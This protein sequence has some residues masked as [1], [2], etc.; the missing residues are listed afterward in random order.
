MRVLHG[1]ARCPAPAGHLVSPRTTGRQMTMDKSIET[2]NPWIQILWD[3]DGSDLLLSAGT[4]PRIRVNGRLLPIEGLDP[5][6]GP[7]IDALA[8]PLLNPDQELTFE[9][10]LDVDFSFSWEDKARLRGSL[11]TQRGQTCPRAAN[12]P[13]Q[14]PHVRRARPAECGGLGRQ[15]PPR[16]RLVT[17]PT[18]SGKSTTLASIVNKHQRDALAAHPHDRGPR[19]VRPHPQEVRRQ[20]ARGRDRQP[21]VRPRAPLSTARGPRR[22]A[23]R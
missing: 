22:P 18:G 14:D 23:H 2:I 15:P 9:E 20:P 6:T 7:Q 16:V 4:P 19:R 13:H 11:F 5:M 12:H 1:A 10:Q 8:R 17:G 21:V 3:Q